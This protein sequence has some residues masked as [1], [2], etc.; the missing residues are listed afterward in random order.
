MFGF[1]YL[2]PNCRKEKCVFVATDS[3]LFASVVIFRNFLRAINTKM[4]QVKILRA[5]KA[6][7]VSIL[8]ILTLVITNFLQ[9]Y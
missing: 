2:D 9:V 4:R 6:L 5:H 7:V 8:G 3:F 1:R